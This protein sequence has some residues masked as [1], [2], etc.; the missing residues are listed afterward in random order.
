MST[1]SLAA[2]RDTRPAGAR[3]LVT[4]L[5]CRCAH[6][7]RWR[8]WRSASSSRLARRDGAAVRG[9]AG[10]PA[11]QARQ[12]AAT[13]GLCFLFTL[14][15]LGDLALLPRGEEV[16]AD[17]AEHEVRA[18]GDD[19]GTDVTRDVDGWERTAEELVL[20]DEV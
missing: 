13:R 4:S 18:G 1:R 20:A 17:R 3:S 9:R 15:G 8:S 14:D 10:A 2:G 19:V 16:H 6:R 5:R 12:G 7:A 11:P